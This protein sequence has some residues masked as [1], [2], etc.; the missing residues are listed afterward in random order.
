M[1]DYRLTEPAQ[2]D[3]LALAEFIAQDHPVVAH[4][5]LDQLES[6]MHRLAERPG[7]GHSRRDLTNEEGILF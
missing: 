6:A 2:R 4:Q 1:A 7:M 5:V 3:L